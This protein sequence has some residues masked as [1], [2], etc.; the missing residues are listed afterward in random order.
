MGATSWRYYTPHRPLPEDALQALRA[1]VFARGEYTQPAESIDDLLLPNVRRL[2]R[3]PAS[4][5]QRRQV[6]QEL[7]VHR[8][9]ETGDMSGL[10][11]RFGPSRGKSVLSNRER[12][13]ERPGFAVAAPL[14]PDS[15]RQGFGTDQ[16]TREDV[17]QRWSGVAEQLDR[18]QA[19]YL[20]VYRD[21]EPH[22]YAFIGSSGD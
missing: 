14:S 3:N 19:R 13:S 20:V 21:G 12:V 5:E 15:L 1:L 9:I 17:E 2:G 6:E 11:P 10:S 4:P 22:E 16:P 7:Q 18:W 8:A